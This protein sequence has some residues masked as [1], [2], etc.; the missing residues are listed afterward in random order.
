MDEEKKSPTGREAQ[1][2]LEEQQKRFA[3]EEK[4]GGGTA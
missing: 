4:E 2:A 3:E 1:R